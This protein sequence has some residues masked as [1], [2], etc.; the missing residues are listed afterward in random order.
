MRKIRF[1]AVVMAI[2]M[3]MPA[4]M[5]CRGVRTKNN[6]VKEDDPWFETTR[7]KLDKD[8]KKYETVG[9][10]EVCTSND[11]LF[12]IYP[13]TK[14]MW[15]SCRTVLDTYDLAGNLLERKEL[16]CPDGFRVQS[17]YS[18][19]SDPE[20][21]T[22]KAG[23]YLNSSGKRFQAFIDI[24]TE[25]GVVSNIKDIFDKGNTFVNDVWDIDLAGDYAVVTCDDSFNKP[26][27]SFSMMLFKNS[28]LV[29]E[30]D[31]SAVHINYIYEGVS[32]DPSTDSLYVTG[33]EKGE[34]IIME[35]D[36]NNCKLKDKRYP[37]D[38]DDK[39]A[40]IAE[41]SATG[42]GELCKLDTSGNIMKADINTMIPETVIDATWQT[43][44]CNPLLTDDVYTSTGILSCTDDRTVIL[45]S[46][47]ESYGMFDSKTYE[48]ITVLEK[49][50]RNPHAGKEIIEIALCFANTG[51]S[52]YLS[53]AIYEFNKADNE[54]LIRLWDKHKSGYTLGKGF[55][56]AG[57]AESE[58]YA[59]IED[60][61]GIEGPDIVINA[62][63]RLAM[64]DDVLMDLSEFLEPEVMEKQY[65]NIIEAGRTGGEL[66]FLPVVLEIEGLVI[67]AD[68]IKDG[69]SG[70]TFEEFDRMVKEELNGFSPYD[71]PFSFDYNKDSFVRSCIDTRSAV[72]G[73]T[74][75]FGTDQ[76][77]SAVEYA[78]DN[79]I[80][81]DKLSITIEYAYD[82]QH[83]QKTECC[84]TKIADYLDFVTACYKQDG[85]YVIIGTP[86]TDASGP[87]FNA[88]ETVSVL[89][90]TDV[91]DGCSKFI[92]FLF[93]GKAFD[94]SEC[95]FRN[96][97][98]NKEIMSRNT[99]ILTNRNNEV[100]DQ[101][102]KSKD[103]GAIR[104]ELSAERAEGDK[105]ATDDMLGSFLGS[106]ATISN[107]YYEDYEINVFIREETLPYYAGDR[108]LDDVI[109]ILNDRTTKYI[110]E[111]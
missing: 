78:K 5:S 97:V 25:T 103:S 39:K 110:R 9:D 88:V 94:S 34:V 52:D 33:L 69:A 50:D 7:F 38:P 99:E 102:L 43:P 54:Y 44:F 22:I 59:L 101:Y 92:N 89:A 3:L 11:R 108:S 87:R 74:I 47:T 82:Y 105:F 72:S 8:I 71:Y 28:E 60:V 67:N 1:T 84:Y 2:V 37:G 104:V 61:K 42:N 91:K 17:I 75:D 66:I 62:P 23:V 35:F 31:M 20:G 16:S 29:G 70:V 83:R 36:L 100:Y 30:L 86:S 49:A 80:Y 65:G 26:E 63:N 111:I 4:L 57:S 79:F 81:D 24:D 18:A 93:A 90:G 76:F 46:V 106:M 56:G 40:N 32:I 95:D 77:R 13:L 73:D 10:S 6:V 107:C 96:I 27:F 21:K 53:K 109:K 48:Y 41:Y 51:V 64:Q 14:D 98:T 55:V 45:D 12:S 58:G 15:G 19:G 85:H 68:L